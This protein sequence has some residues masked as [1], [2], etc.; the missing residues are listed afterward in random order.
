MHS[1]KKIISLLTVSLVSVFALAQNN[2]TEKKEIYFRISDVLRVN[3]TVV[4]FLEEAE[5]L[6]IAKGFSVRAYQTSQETPQKRDFKE[7]GSGRIVKTDTLVMAFIKLFNTKDTLSVGDVASLELNIPSLPYRGVFSTLSFYNIVFNDYDSNPL[8]YLYDMLYSDDPKIEDSIYAI[9]VNDLHATYQKIKD[10]TN[11]SPT[12]T[13]K[14]KEGRYKGR[15]VLDML[16]DATKNDAQEFLTYVS[17]MTNGYIGKKYRLSESFADWLNSNSPYS[18]SDIKKILLPVYKNKTQFEKLLPLYKKDILSE[19][20]V[21]NLCDQAEGLEL[22]EALHLID[23]A[24][25]IAATVNDTAGNARAHLSAARIYFNNKNYDKAIVECDRSIQYSTLAKDKDLEMQATLKKIGCLNRGKK[26]TEGIVLITEVDKKL[27]K[28]RMEL[29]ENIYQKDLQVRYQYEGSIHYARGDYDQA[30][31]AYTK[32][33]D[34]NKGI[35]SYDAIERNASYYKFIGQVNNDQGRPSDALESFK[36]SATIYRRNFDM[37]NWALLQ[38]EIAYSYYNLEDYRKSLAYCDSALKKLLNAR[39]YDEAGYSKSLMGSCYWE[40]GKYDSAVASHKESIALRKMDNNVYGQAD[41]WKEIGQLYLLSGLKKEALNAYDSSGFLYAQIKDSSGLAETYNKKGQVYLNDENY[42]TAVGFFEK[43]RGFNSKTTVESLYNLGLAWDQ[44]DTAKARYY[45]TACKR[46]S[47]STANTGYVFDATKAL[48]ALAYRENK[49]KQGDLLYEECL[50]LSKQLNTPT[51]YGYCLVLKAVRFYNLAEMDSALHYY[52]KALQI[53]DTVSKE[54]AIW[55]LNNIADVKIEM[56]KFDEA[57]QSLM[58][59]IGLAESTSNNLALGYSLETTSFLYGFTG[60]FEKGLKNNDSALAIFTRSGN[61]LRLAN[62]YI[63]RGT[64]LKSMGNYSQSVQSFLL[65]D[66][67]YKAELTNEYRHTALNDIGVVYYNQTDYQNAMK[68]FEMALQGLKKGVVDE[69]YLL[70]AG[71]IAECQY[72]LKK[73]K[74]AEA[75]FTEV[76]PL[77]KEKK[78]NR[79]A[80]GM[81]LGLGKLYYDLKEI[82]KAIEQF[83]YAREYGFASG[84]KEKIIE[85]LTF[86]GRINLLAGKKDSAEINFRK[87]ISVV[88]RY[89]IGGGWEPFYEL[90]LIFYDQKKFDSSITYFKQAVDLLDKNTENLYGGDEAKKI[91]NN[92]P[93]KLDLYNKI[94]F[95]YYNT[96]NIKEAWAYA[97]RSNIAGLKE[98][99]GSITTTT[100]DKEKNDALKKL[101]ALQQSKKALET[102]AEKQMGTDK[103]ETLKKIEIVEADYTNFLQD[104]VE[105]YPDLGSYFSKFNADEFYN[106]KGKLPA[107]VAVTLYLVNDKTLMIFTLTNEKLAVDTMT[108]D[109][110]KLVSAFIAATKQPQVNTN[111]GALHLRSEPTDEDETTAPLP[112]KDVSDQLY[113]ILVAPVID[114][115]KDKK[116][117][118]IIPTGIFSNMPFQCLGQKLPDSAF[119]FLIEDFSIFYTNKMKVFDNTGRDNHQANDLLSFAAFG[120]PD[121]SLHY[122]TEEVKEI[123]KLIGVDSTIYTDSRATEAMAKFSLIHKKYIHFATHGILNY[124]QE[125]SKSYLKFLPDKDSSNGNN[126][127]LTIREIQSLPIDDCDLVTLSA[128]ETAITKELVKGW[129]ISPANSFLER[130]V[131]S[132]IASLWKVDDEATSILMNEFYGNLNKK[133]DK[134]DALRLAQETL[135]K[136]PK[137]SHPFYWGAFVLYGEWR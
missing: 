88:T 128:C 53:L 7:V 122:N 31:K 105:K 81:A 40:L 104:V 25:A 47:D 26:F 44:I 8:Y 82:P 56:G 57:E 13:E 108:A 5:D 121:Q 130:N 23:F 116:R 67:I 77:A 58:K 111:T 134:V 9:I 62:T 98:L 15:S 76:F 65:A 127:R 69:P 50:G 1:L 118:C 37:L 112:F 120:V 68:Y 18:Y 34:I 24:E 133:M 45:Y 70:Y 22:S 21:S 36:K 95:S 89:K 83:N 119:H 74:E 90:G 4:V 137:F 135:S 17:D 11:L 132:V 16:R 60:D 113:K 103:A 3:D 136:N 96:D 49:I 85:A 91:F 46:K 20:A 14:A 30:L 124:S 27:E 94:I 75:G 115:I 93:R 2:Q 80:S 102:T 41:S 12:L 110:N 43:A 114:K 48:A 52:D 29:G 79:I 87:A 6:G 32:A 84:E 54:D 97:N 42:K 66:S 72:Y 61:T 28:Y 131:K 92:D 19:H 78:L 123:G 51:S 129:T 100:N 39:Y 86:L 64:L 63:S 126:G 35:N 109:V 73:Y 55:Q 71:N 59:A 33:I 10:R 38:N 125:F 101:I 99:S 117:L 107:D 106:Y